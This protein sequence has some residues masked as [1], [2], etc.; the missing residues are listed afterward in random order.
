MLS[1]GRSC[2]DE[3]FELCEF[4]VLV[5]Y[6]GIFFC[7]SIRYMVERKMED[8]GLVLLDYVIRVR[9]VL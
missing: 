7:G 2:V 3:V 8:S 9:V 5:V 1:S 6:G 4:E